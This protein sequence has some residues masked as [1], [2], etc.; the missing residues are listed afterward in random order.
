MKFVARL[1]EA[2]I[3]VE[4]TRSGSRYEVHI[5]GH[6]INADLVRANGH[7]Q[8]LR[9]QDGKHYLLT[10]HREGDR[11][12]VSFGGREVQLELLDPL[13]LKR[14]RGGEGKKTDRAR[15]KANM[16]GRVVR[17]LVEPGTE[18]TAGD[19]L[20]ILEAMKMENE[21]TAPHSG[22]VTAVHVQPGQTVESDAELVDIE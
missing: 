2:T 21:I 4:V 9:I 7:L 20:L 18:V 10:H 3:P 17:V 19:G 16:P 15:V 13:A 22:K 5:N 14:S 8:S 11:H 1:G 6:V 12:A